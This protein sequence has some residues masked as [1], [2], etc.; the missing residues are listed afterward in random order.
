MSAIGFIQN[1][2]NRCMPAAQKAKLGDVLADLVAAVNAARSDLSAILAQLQ[3]GI[4]IP[5]V[6]A[7][8]G[9]GSVLVKTSALVVG[10]V[11]GTAFSIAA[12]TDAPALAGTTADTMYSAY[13][14]YSDNTGT[15]TWSAKTADSASEA[16]ALALLPALPADKIRLG[17]VTIHN[18][19]GAPFVANTT[20]LDA[21]GITPAY[22]NAA[23]AAIFGAS[24]SSSVVTDIESRH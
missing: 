7:I 6:L 19:S 18:A 11:G 23:V 20:H 21:A 4:V 13:D 3:T 10:R 14:L 15:M 2:L 16:A 8:H 9:A 1:Q 5:A 24:V 17:S 12:N 22:Y